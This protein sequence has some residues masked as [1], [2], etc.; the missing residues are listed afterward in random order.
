MRGRIANLAPSLRCAVALVVLSLIL[1][2][3]ADRAGSAPSSHPAPGQAAGQAPTPGRWAAPQPERPVTAFELE[4]LRANAE[5]RQYSGP[6][7]LGTEFDHDHWAKASRSAAWI[8]RLASPLLEELAA[9]GCVIDISAYETC[10][11]VSLVR[12]LRYLV[13]AVVAVG[14]RQREAMTRYTLLSS[15]KSSSLE[16]FRRGST[17]SIF[18]HEVIVADEGMHPL[19]LKLI[20]RS[21]D[22]HV[23]EPVNDLCVCAGDQSR[24]QARYYRSG[25]ESKDPDFW[26]AVPRDGMPFFAPPKYGV[27]FL[28]AGKLVFACPGDGDSFR[29]VAAER[30]IGLSKPGGATNLGRVCVSGLSQAVYLVESEDATGARDRFVAFPVADG[31]G[32]VRRLGR[33]RVTCYENSIRSELWDVRFG[34]HSLLKVPLPRAPSQYSR[35]NWKEERIVVTEH[36]A[37]FDPPIAVIRKDAEWKPF[38]EDYVIDNR[39]SFEG[40][41]DDTARLLCIFASIEP[42]D[43]LRVIGALHRVD[44]TR[45]LADTELLAELERLRTAAPARVN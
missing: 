16:L 25:P 13:R 10:F 31:N 34:R 7:I 35:N 15:E 27:S 8:P 19:P 29:L 11:P 37:A 39:L 5:A 24:S 26:I 41:D 17:N 14:G 6:L 12:D 42:D 28:E 22:I 3:I 32:G 4:R 20:P 9:R 23:P 45:L 30:L 44:V 18:P 40:A 2:S 33:G 21:S 43:L 38:A 1:L 36:F